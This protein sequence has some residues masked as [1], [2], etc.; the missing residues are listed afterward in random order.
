MSTISEFELIKQYFDEITIASHFV[1]LGI[2]DDCALLRCPTD[3]QLAVSVDT[4]VAGVHFFPDVAPDRLGYKCLAVNLSDLAA[5]GATPAW[6]TLAITLPEANA[7]WLASFTQGLAEAAKRYDIPLVG[8]DTTKGPLSITIQVHG[9]IEHGQALRRD[10]AKVGDSIYVS[11]TLG[12]AGAGLAIKQSEATSLSSDQD[13]LIERLECPTP[14][15]SIGQDLLGIANAAIDISDGLIADLGHILTAS[16]VG[17]ELKLGSLPIS[18]AL[19]RYADSV[20]VQSQF[21]LY[22]GDD[23][24]LCFTVSAEK[25]AML[26]DDLLK[27][28]QK[29]GQITSGQGVRLMQHGQPIEL[30]GRSYDHFQ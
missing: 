17:A 20:D 27:Q 1:E 22:S 12:D 11:G 8:G 24:E 13:Y 6:F 28:C 16:K 3:K 19:S 14:R 10:Q 29:V 25:T 26:S 9:F 30:E 2:G 4:L 18:P 23:Y 5:M 15:L 7:G 21:A